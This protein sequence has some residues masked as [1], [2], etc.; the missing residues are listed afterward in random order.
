MAL[1]RWQDLCV[2]AND[3]GVMAA[4][5]SPVLA[6][7]ASP[8]TRPGVIRLSGERPEQTVWLN[9][10]PEVKTV[11]NRVHLDLR[12]DLDA[13]LALGATVVREPDEE[14]SWHVLVDPEGNE[15]CLLRGAG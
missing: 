3:A 12:V 6:L 7:E 4:F 14:I 11:K 9:T 10:V 8:H 1:A 15:F 2:D 5:W 13:V